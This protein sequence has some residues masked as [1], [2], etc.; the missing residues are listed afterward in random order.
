MFF[1]PGWLIALFTFPGVIIHEIAH[2]IFCHWAGVPV[3]DVRYFRPM[4]NPAGYVVHGTPPNLR[5]GLL[6][7]IGPLIVNSLLC[8]LL[9]FAS[10]IPL[11]V[12]QDSQMP[13]ASGFLFWIGISAGMHAFPSNHDADEFLNLMYEKRGEDRLLTMFQIFAWLLRAVNALR[14]IWIDLIYAFVLTA[15]LPLAFG[16]F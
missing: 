9:T 7:A 10:A 13:A 6:I 3:Y 12:L 15:I 8:M 16:L 4:A 5:S 1:I 2:R 11:V 14:V